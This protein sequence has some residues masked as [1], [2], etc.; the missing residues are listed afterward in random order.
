M[1]RAEALSPARLRDAAPLFAALGDATRLGLLVSLCSSGPLSV[2]RLS[3]KFE[4]SRQALT[5]HLDVL[6]E[7]GLVR[8]SREGRERIWELEPKRLDDAHAYLERLSRQWDDALDR[9]KAFV[10]R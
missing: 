3:A 5:K 1:S 10:E 7:A 6:A 4:V 2:T 9:L 8:S